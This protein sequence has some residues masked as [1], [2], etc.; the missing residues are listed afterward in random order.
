MLPEIL[1]DSTRR[2]SNMT[3]VKIAGCGVSNNEK[4]I[5]RVLTHQQQQI[6]I[7]RKFPD[8][9]LASGEPSVTACS[10]P[11]TTGLVEYSLQELDWW[12]LPGCEAARSQCR[13]G[14]PL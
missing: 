3:T 14:S 9:R 4:V 11:G 7:D 8:I 13:G 6:N 1:A 5:H 12:K 2:D 10:V